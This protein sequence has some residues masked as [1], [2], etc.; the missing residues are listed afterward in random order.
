M[1]G[2]LST[3]FFVGFSIAWVILT[4][5]AIYG[6]KKKGEKNDDYDERQQ[7]VRYRGYKNSFYIIVLYLACVSLMEGIM[8]RHLIDIDAV[9]IIGICLSVGVHVIYCIW[10]EGYFPVK[11][12]RKSF[13][14][15]AVAT[16]ILFISFSIEN[17]KSGNIIVDG[18]LTGN[19]V[20][21][22]CAILF[23]SVCIV[24]FIKRA[25]EKK[26]DEQQ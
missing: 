8:N 2:E 11:N 12:N 6:H 23:T 25:I 21:L 3:A 10:N 4:I 17:I 20:N 26:E 7:L 14:I 19:C 9:T 13:T 18:V 5:T 15:M 22:V 1:G 16:A 24:I